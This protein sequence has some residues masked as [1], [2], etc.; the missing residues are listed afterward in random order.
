MSEL[1]VGPL[2]A[3][4][5]YHLGT[6]EAE[7]LAF[8]PL[9]ELAPMDW[10]RPGAVVV[11][12]PHPDD[13]V[14]GVGAT[15]RHL[16]RAGHA[17]SVVNVTDGEGSHPGSAAI[18]PDELVARR[19]REVDGA[20]EHLGLSGAAVDRRRL[21]DGGVA[22]HEAELGTQLA[23]RLAGVALCLAPW[24]LDGHPDHDA[25]GRAAAAACL[26]TG[27]RLVEY[28]LWAW[29]WAGPVDSPLP[30]TRARRVELDPEDR[31]AKAAAVAALTS[32]IE[33]LGPDPADGP[34]LPG[35]VLA[36]FLRAFE[37]VLA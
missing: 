20:L 11:V 22:A 10:G 9:R 2:L 3:V 31:R 30:W 13:E 36:R 19:R 12:A 28:P 7:W 37:V 1:A 26:L 4:D 8:P 18:S 5:A 35:P 21:P 25:T 34:V 29:H 6:T 14:L 24:R 27:T 23:D 15:M 16:L 33:A 32:Q 17:V